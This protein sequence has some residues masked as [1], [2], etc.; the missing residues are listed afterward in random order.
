N[1]GLTV[2]T[3]ESTMVFGAGADADRPDW[4]PTYP[5]GEV[6]G[7]HSVSVGSEQSGTFTVR[8]SDDVG[9][10]TAFYQEQLESAG[11]DV[12][13]STMNIDGHETANLSGTA[14]SRTVNVTIT[15]DGDRT[16][17]LVAYGEKS[18]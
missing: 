12:R 17:A 6:G 18:N 11:F 1:G 5:G 16:Q 7:V 13:K 2:T 15:R 4:V 9:A 14:G 3:D 8:S 10:V